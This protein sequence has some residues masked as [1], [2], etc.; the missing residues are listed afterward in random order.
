MDGD[1]PEDPVSRV[2]KIDWRQVVRIADEM[3]GTTFY[4]GIVDQSVRTHLRKG[5]YRYINPSMY[6]AW[7]E[8][9]GDGTKAHLFVRRKP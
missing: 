3:P 5:R 4:V 6:E 1:S 2:R 7:T 8:K 9:T